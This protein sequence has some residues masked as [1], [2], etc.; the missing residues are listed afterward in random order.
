MTFSYVVSAF[1]SNFS[2]FIRSSSNINSI[3]GLDDVI[4]DQKAGGGGNKNC[5]GVHFF[6]KIVWRGELKKSCTYNKVILYSN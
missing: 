2:L 1:D 6:K 3:S 5:H 4:L